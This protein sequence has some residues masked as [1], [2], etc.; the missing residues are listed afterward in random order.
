MPGWNKMI[1]VKK[2][3]LSVLFSLV[4]SFLCFA[5]GDKVMHYKDFIG[6]FNGYG[7]KPFQDLSYSISEG[8][9]SKLPVMFR[10]RIGS[11]PGN[12]RVLGHG[13]ALNDAIPRQT[14][15][16]L[17]QTYPGK[18]K[19]IIDIWRTFAKQI[20][21]DAVSTTGLPTK[22]ANAFASL[23]Y[24]IHL[25]GDVEPDN[26][27]IDLVLSPKSI[28]RNIN[29]DSRILFQNNPQYADLIQ[30]RL[31]LV[32]RQMKGKNPQVTAQIL[33][34]ELHRLHMGDML[35]NTW[36]NTFKPEYSIDR[37]IAANERLAQRTLQ[38]V[39]GSQEQKL[40]I[41][42]PMAKKSDF[43]Q[44]RADGKM[45][46]PGFLACDGRLLLAVK[47]GSKTALVVFAVEGGIA[48]YQYFHGDILKQ[49]YP[50]KIFQA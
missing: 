21:G 44:K 31:F 26:K 30:R 27:L 28:V 18:E 14:L 3:F 43:Y 7:D 35:K 33:M 38:R 29:K 9:D 10:E 6:V 45:L 37:V 16:Y 46:H 42:R 13:W 15:D 34:D 8:I 24:D 23:L 49:S 50:I 40:A 20:T 12:H 2:I 5:H 17:C 22:Q 48:S 36:G 1:V 41:T 4:L 25:L 11:I 19:E 32:M 39:P 47:E